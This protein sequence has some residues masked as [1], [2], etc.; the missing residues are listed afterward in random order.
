MSGVGVEAMHSVGF[1]VG[2]E[3]LIVFG[4]LSL[5]IWSRVF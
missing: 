5:F 4:L 2:G 3:L 1:V